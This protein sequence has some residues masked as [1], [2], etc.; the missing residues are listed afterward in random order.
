MDVRDQ[1]RAVVNDN[2]RLQGELNY[3]IQ[4]REH[5]RAEMKRKD[6][7]ID[8]VLSVCYANQF[9]TVDTREIERAVHGCGECRGCVSL[10]AELA[11]LQYHVERQHSVLTKKQAR[12][13]A[14]IALCDL[15]TADRNA[16]IGIE[17]VR[18]AAT[19]DT[20]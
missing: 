9:G 5:D 6:D 8:R 14:V 19:G 7:T 17:D 20:K 18:A 15:A 3:Q 2:T 11:A 1:L 12:L 16:E 10:R 13:D 4:L